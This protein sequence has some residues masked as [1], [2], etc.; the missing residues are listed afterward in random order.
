MADVLTCVAASLKDC[1]LSIRE[2]LLFRLHQVFLSGATEAVDQ[3]GALMVSALDSEHV[4][5]CL[6]GDVSP[7]D[8][9]VFIRQLSM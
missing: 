8:D 4:P 2:N 5:V 3:D 9:A 1:P 6:H 7:V